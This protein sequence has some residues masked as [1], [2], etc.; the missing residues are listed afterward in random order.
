[1]A[2]KLEVV[3][4]GDTRGLSQAFGE[5]E[6]RAGKFSAKMSSVGS[7]V[8]KGV[9]VGVLGA[10]SALAV[11]GPQLIDLGGKLDAWALKVDT[12]FEGS[13]D[14]VR[15]WADANNEAMGLTDEELAGLAA[16]FGDLL[17][18]MGFTAKE[19]ALMSRDVVGLSG[20]LSEW[21]GGSRSAAEVS[22]IL[23]KAMLGERDSLKE[24]GISITEADVQAR[25]A[26]KGQKDL[27]G[28][29]LEQAKALA[30]QELIFEKST[31]AQKAYAEGGNSTIRAGNKLK[32]V[33]GEIQVVLAQKLIPALAKGVDYL[34]KI[35]DAVRPVV[36]P[37]VAFIQ[38][39]PAPFLVGFATAL[40][41]VAAAMTALAIAENAALIPVYL[42]IGAIA[43][44]AGGL[45]YAYQNVDW[46]RNAVDAV[47]SFITGT[48]VPAIQSLWHW[49]QDNL[50]PII[51]QIAQF[52]V[53]T[54]KAAFE[55]AVEAVG[56]L[57]GKLSELWDWFTVN[58]LPTL[59]VVAAWLT[60][61]FT[62]AWQSV[63][64]KVQSVVAALMTVY[65]WFGTYVLPLLKV[66]G[67]WLADT[68]VSN[69][70]TARDALGWVVD[71]AQA[72]WEWLDKV[73]TIAGEAATAV[74]SI[75][76]GV[77]SALNPFD[78]STRSTVGVRRVARSSRAAPTS[79][80]NAARRS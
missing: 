75:G 15:K 24:L 60:S 26:A 1:M 48:V 35:A 25:L 22:E 29:A 3:I 67:A 2:K 57:I 59:K 49:F 72:I 18:P 8:S 74:Q 64:E 38:K 73:K 47:A 61:T 11:M 63:S 78:N 66:V 13:A 10:A 7:S 23:A 12:V 69:L 20:A 56:W 21:S 19:A 58:I 14:S 70:G 50:L 53:T 39:N 41:I 42:I 4:T 6:K 55:V 77:A 31:D 40:G 27:T 45:V 16:N 54:Y 52:Y 46:F 33:W 28:A 51:Q 44:L 43:V 36:E 79:S 76:G 32:A 30:T 68:F 65:E 71:K 37:I 62:A 80:V 9:G 34:F 5:A 17:K